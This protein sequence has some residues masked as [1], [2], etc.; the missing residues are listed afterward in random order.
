MRQFYYKMGRFDY[1]MRQSLQNATFVINCDCTD[2]KVSTSWHYLFWWS[3][4][5]RNISAI[6]SEKSV[7]TAFGFC[8]DAKHSD[9]LQ[10][11]SQVCCYL[12]F[13]KCHKMFLT[14]SPF[15]IAS[16]ERKWNRTRLSSA[17][18]EC[19]SCLTSSQII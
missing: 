13:S 15:S 18:T 16:L 3:T 11:S 7:A 9:I 4:Q 5:N 2:I 1:K 6:Y 8:C 19:K 12:L 10:G 14:F 17:E